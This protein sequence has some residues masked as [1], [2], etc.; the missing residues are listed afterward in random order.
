MFVL[1][2]VAAGPGDVRRLVEEIE[3]TYGS[4]TPID[5]VL[6]FGTQPDGDAIGRLD[7]AVTA[8]L[9]VAGVT[10][11]AVRPD[12]YI[13]LRHDGT[14]HRALATYLEALAG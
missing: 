8:Q 2:G 13:G 6:G 3:V 11:L 9:G 1:G 4:M 10:T 14:D 5:A 7:E 12:R